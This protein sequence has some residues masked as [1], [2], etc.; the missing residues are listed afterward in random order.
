MDWVW[1]ESRSETAGLKGG[2][3]QRQGGSGPVADRAKSRALN[4]RL[5]VASCPSSIYHSSSPDRQSAR[6]TDGRGIGSQ[7][8]PT[9][10]FRCQPR[11]PGP[12]QA[13]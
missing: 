1:L 12:E 4:A 5:T 6:R 9:L 10:V 8:C 2:L 13:T 3:G 7:R 11:I